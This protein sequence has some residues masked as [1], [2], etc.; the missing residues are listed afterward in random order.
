[1]IIWLKNNY[2]YQITNCMTEV[3]DYKKHF[4]LIKIFFNVWFINTAKCRISKHTRKFFKENKK[5]DH[6]VKIIWKAKQV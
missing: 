6:Y 4:V 3:T 2:D 1:M 5:G